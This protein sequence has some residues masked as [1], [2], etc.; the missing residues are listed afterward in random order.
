LYD[1]AKEL[2][3]GVSEA[4]IGNFEVVRQA[5]EM[6]ATALNQTSNTH[7][8]IA[9][10]VREERDKVRK[11]S[12]VGRTAHV[13][14]DQKEVRKDHSANKSSKDKPLEI[15]QKCF[16]C[17]AAHKVF[18]CNDTCQLSTCT[19]P[20]E[21]HSAKGCPSISNDALFQQLLKVRYNN[22]VKCSIETDLSCISCCS[23]RPLGRAARKQYDTGSNVVILTGKALFGGI[24]TPN[25]TNE[26]VSAEFL[27]SLKEKRSH[28]KRYNISNYSKNSTHEKATR[29]KA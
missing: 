26:T 18:E 21:K 22:Y 8:K 14:T 9:A 24:V 3:K 4:E 17:P 27:Y 13:V 16:N 7:E 12:A 19:I 1:K 20:T 11:A 29:Y 6:D 5:I 28:P 25:D 15:G 2:A 10:A 23:G